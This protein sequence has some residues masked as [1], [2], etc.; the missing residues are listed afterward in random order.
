MGRASLAEA[1]P[2]PEGMRSL[3]ASE[4]GWASP[5]L[6]RDGEERVKSTLGSAAI[7]S[8]PKEGGS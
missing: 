3:P 6:E 1:R 8:E 5:G 2:A 7:N 4:Q